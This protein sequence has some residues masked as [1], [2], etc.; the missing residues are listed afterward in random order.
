MQSCP[1]AILPPEKIYGL[2]SAK[3]H[4]L[5]RELAYTKKVFTFLPVLSKIVIDV[6]FLINLRGA[7][8][9]DYQIEYAFW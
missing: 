9:V 7:D 5:T 1:L 4:L 3:N 6:L 2:N 8:Y